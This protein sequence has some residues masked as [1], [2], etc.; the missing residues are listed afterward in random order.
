MEDEA[1]DCLLR[2]RRAQH[3]DRHTALSSWASGIS[4][5]IQTADT[6]GVGDDLL[7]LDAEERAASDA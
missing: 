2:S 3:L 1:V 7:D 6:A 4:P 5:M